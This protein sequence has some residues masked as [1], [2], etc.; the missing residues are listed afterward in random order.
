MIPLM[1][2]NNMRITI[3]LNAINLF[4]QKT[5]TGFQTTPYRDG[6]NVADATFFGGFDPVAVASAQNFRP[7]RAIRHGQRLP[8]SE[9]DP[10][11]G[12]VHVLI[13]SA[14]AA[15]GSRLADSGIRDLGSG[16]ALQSS[17]RT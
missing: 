17:F 11:A 2:T 16:R 1:T 12:E 5:V 14:L 4:D 8:G 15:R 9:G 13:W 7:E 10:G 6:F 3:G